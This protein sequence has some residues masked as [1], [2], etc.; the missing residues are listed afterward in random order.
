MSLAVILHPLV[1]IARA[2]ALMPTMLCVTA[3]PLAVVYPSPHLV[4]ADITVPPRS[5]YISNKAHVPYKQLLAHAPFQRHAVSRLHRELLQTRTAEMIL[6][7]LVVSAACLS[8]VATHDVV[9]RRIR[10]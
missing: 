4:D 8:S 2:I 3:T 6:Q 9:Y 1:A 10:Q 7:L 5:P